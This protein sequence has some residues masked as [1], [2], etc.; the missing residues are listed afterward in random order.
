MLQRLADVVQ[1]VQQRVLA[2]RVDVEVDFLAVRP[3]H[4]LALEIDGDARV[5]A[6][7]RIVDQRIADRARQADR[8][9]AVL[10]A[11]VVEDVAERWRDDAADAEIGQRP[12]SVLARRA[13]AE[14]LV[15]D[16]DLR[17]AVAAPGSG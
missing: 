5:A 11:V 4:H 7:F 2:E 16:D 10:E 3:D 8:Q 17:V 14:V 1:P 6:E 9:Q 15:R 13:A 12:R